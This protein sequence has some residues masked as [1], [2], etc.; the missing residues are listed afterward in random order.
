MAA[1]RRG[2]RVATCENASELTPSDMPNCAIGLFSCRHILEDQEELYHEYDLRPMRCRRPGDH[3]LEL[4]LIRMQGASRHLCQ[5]R[6]KIND[7]E[8]THGRISGKSKTVDRTGV[9]G[10]ERKCH[11]RGSEGIAQAE[12]DGSS[13]CSSN[14]EKVGLAGTL[15]A[16]AA[17]P[18]MT[19]WS[20]GERLYSDA[21]FISAL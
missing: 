12:Q 20:P 3:S 17:C 2:L 9:F 19:I 8:A 21:T 4:C 14:S 7:K 5:L 18:V 1:R 11:W 13:A 16:I 10:G 6:S 15:C